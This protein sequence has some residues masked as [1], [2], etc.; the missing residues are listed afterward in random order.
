MAYISPSF[1]HGYDKIPDRSSLREEGQFVLVTL[2][3]EAAGGIASVV[4]SHKRTSAGAQL[5]FPCLFS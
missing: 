1:P 3:S 5:A 4:R 2:E